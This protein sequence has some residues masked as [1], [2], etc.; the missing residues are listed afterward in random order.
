MQTGGFSGLMYTDV[1]LRGSRS[2]ERSAIGRL[3]AS[4]I[5]FV[6]PTLPGASGFRD[7]FRDK[8]RLLP[9]DP[10]S[11]ECTPSAQMRTHAEVHLASPSAAPHPPS[12]V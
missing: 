6:E 1:S 9:D 12:Y 7:R 4:R 10:S 8:E 5:T 11:G 3:R 2:H